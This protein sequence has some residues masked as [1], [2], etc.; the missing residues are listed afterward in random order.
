[1]ENSTILARLCVGSNP[2]HTASFPTPLRQ[3][4]RGIRS[5]P[6]SAFLS[7]PLFA[8]KL[9]ST[10]PSAPNRLLQQIPF[11]KL[12]AEGCDACRLSTKKDEKNGEKFNATA[13]F[14]KF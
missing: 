12:L 1:M 3:K 2:G 5:V 11:A 14:A 6:G 9:A 7:Y 8:F 13:Q 4:P 10:K